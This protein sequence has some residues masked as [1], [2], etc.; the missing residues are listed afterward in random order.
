M[1]EARR[2]SSI[3]SAVRCAIVLAIFVGLP[4]AAWRLMSSMEGSP[5]GAAEEFLLA[6]N[7]G[8]AAA[9]RMACEPA[10]GIPI[11]AALRFEPD[12]WGS[13]WAFI[14]GPDDGNEAV[15]RVQLQGKDGKK[16]SAT[17]VVSKFVRWHVKSLELDGK[18]SFGPAE[19]P[20]GMT[21]PDIRDVEV[22]KTGGGGVDVTYVVTALTN[23]E[24]AGGRSANVNRALILKA[25]DGSTPFRSETTTDVAGNGAG[26]HSFTERL[27][28]R[29]GPGRYV[30]RVV[31]TDSATLL[32][33]TKDIEFTLP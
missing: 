13:G 26:S 25:P 12:A 7:R 18:S 16:R 6:M 24:R 5:D 23:A 8:D 11:E 32:S 33:A 2:S 21:M 10:A 14:I 15:V 30:L 28:V 27:D 9:A 1:P 20:A 29:G 4:L 17:I 31:V 19:L 3:R 22:R